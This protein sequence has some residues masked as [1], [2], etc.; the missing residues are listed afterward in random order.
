M[1]L[2]F[3]NGKDETYTM[4]YFLESQSDADALF[5]KVNSYPVGADKVD[6]IGD[7]AFRFNG[8]VQGQPGDLQFK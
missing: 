4:S 2:W 8:S 1:L 3:Q 6:G 5:R 7:L